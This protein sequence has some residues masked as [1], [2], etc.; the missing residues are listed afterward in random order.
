MSLSYSKHYKKLSKNYVIFRH[1]H[2]STVNYPATCSRSGT[3]PNVSGQ[4]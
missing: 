1:Y 3:R 2:K 4:D